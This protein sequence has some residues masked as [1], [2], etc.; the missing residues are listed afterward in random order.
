M[1][2]IGDAKM[3]LMK[4]CTVSAAC[5]STR[6]PPI[7]VSAATENRIWKLIPPGGLSE[8]V[9]GSFCLRDKLNIMFSLV[10]PAWL[11][12]FNVTHSPAIVWMEA[13]L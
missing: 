1:E 3:A 7:M 11:A 4:C 10:V 9:L 8:V 13:S 6:K 2:V 5:V 12:V